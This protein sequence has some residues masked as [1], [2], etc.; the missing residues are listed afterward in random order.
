MRT[1]KENLPEPRE[2]VGEESRDYAEKVQH[3]TKAEKHRRSYSSA[4]LREMSNNV[5]NW[6]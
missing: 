1:K 5:G 6:I 2:D 4:S 3:M